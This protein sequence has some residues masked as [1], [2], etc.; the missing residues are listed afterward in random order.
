MK[1]IFISLLAIAAI[2]SCAKTEDVFTEGDSEIKL[3]PV[4]KLQ[5]KAKHFGAVD[6][7]VYPTKENFDVYAYWKNVP[8]GNEFT[9]GSMFLEGK[10]AGGAE[11]TNKGN[12]WGGMV[13]YY[14]PKNGSLRFAAYSPADL[15]VDHMLADDLYTISNYEQP[16]NTA[17]TWDFL[18]APTSPSYSLM[19]ATEKV[20]IEFQHALSWITLKVVAKDADA[21]KAFDIKK[22]TINNVL[23]KANFAAKMGDGIQYNEWMGQN[24]EASYVV[25]EG[26]QKVTETVTDIETTPAG[27]LVIPQNTTSVTVD[28]D[29]YG[30]N[31]T[32]DTPGMTITLDLVLDGDATPWEPG[33]HYNYTLVFGLDKIL[34]NPSVADWTEVEVGELDPDAINVSTAAQLEAALANETATKIVFQNNIA[35]DFTVPEVAGRTLTIDGNG[36]ELT[37]SFF[38][39]GKSNYTGAT[40]VYENIDFKTADASTM[41][42]DAFIYCGEEKGT[43]FRYPDGITVKNCT[44]EATGAA[45]EKAVAVKVWSLNGDLVVDGCSAKGLHSLMQL[46]SCGEADVTVHDVKVENCKNGISL[47]NSGNATIKKSNIVTKEY[48]VRAE[49]TTV[50]PDATLTVI[51]SEIDALRP[52]IVRKLND[53]SMTY[54]VALEDAELL[55]GQPFAVVFTKNNDNV[56]FVAPTGKYT[57][58]GAEGYSIFP[59]NA[60][61]S[62]ESFEN[63]L[64]DADVD[65]IDITAALGY[66]DNE[67]VTI[68]KDVTI[69]ANGNKI[70]A[71]GAS[72]LTPSMAVMGDYDVV[73]N[74]ANIE[75]GF[76]GAYY[77]AN[78]VV[79]GG[80]LK[81]TEGMS[82]RNCFY[83]ASTDANTS[84]IT[85]NN[86]DVNM[87]NAS[88]NT[89]L[90]AHGNAVIYVNGGKF[91]GK[92]VGSSNPYV[93]E[94]SI[95]TYTGEV[96]IQGGTFNFDPSEWVPAGYTAVK[97]GE[98]WTVSKN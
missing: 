67:N 64:A 37:G 29:Q 18:V 82:G 81:Y 28:F 83:A 6:G 63:V 45:V 30:I 4:T 75:G 22:V 87:A 24:T 35:G 17:A 33:K 57:I 84:V 74:E 93:K 9:D 97:N 16:S 68:Q 55:P 73:L 38:M 8:A 53:A 34:I 94:A 71:G 44:F 43:N 23:T 59:K 2:A 14:W 47:G 86:V 69:N 25:F 10:E 15:D 51:E 11:F 52:I 1:K 80:S 3:S 79:N 62:K 78:L 40:T 19:T 58:T 49:L 56:D 66:A 61:T 31:G 92:P 13:N 21:A 95:G 12:Y 36:F 20:A 77:G 42:G 32:A 46:T 76:V 85:I 27:T 98:T 60:A 48:G 39:N 50:T 70:T 91:Y 89:Y 96:I 7:I 72:S 88:G 5:T 90:C 41:T 54:N 26:T 65:K